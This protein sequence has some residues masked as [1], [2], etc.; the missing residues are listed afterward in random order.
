[1]CYLDSIAC[2]EGENKTSAHE[3]KNRETNG[4]NNSACAS[5]L[6]HALLGEYGV[7]FFVRVCSWGVSHELVCRCAS[8]GVCRFVEREREKKRDLLGVIIHNGGSRASPAHKL[9]I[10]ML[11]GC[12]CVCVGV[13]EPHM[14]C[15]CLYV[16]VCV[17]VC[18]CVR[19]VCLCVV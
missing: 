9:R 2:F 17:C 6:A 19:R 13:S 16:R 5:S 14:V 10:T 3:K 15:L 7:F 8:S 18:A 1:M 4:V 12:R 11:R